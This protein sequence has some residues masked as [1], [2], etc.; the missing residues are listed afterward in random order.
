MINNEMS[1]SDGQNSTCMRMIDKENQYDPEGESDDY[2][3]E[4]AKMGML[5]IDPCTMRS[6]QDR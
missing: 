2:G 1:V 5:S 6:P 4:A 3:I